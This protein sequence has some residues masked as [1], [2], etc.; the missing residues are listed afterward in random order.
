MHFCHCLLDD[1]DCNFDASID[2]LL[3]GVYQLMGGQVERISQHL[4]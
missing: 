1:G 4:R 3:D 2:R